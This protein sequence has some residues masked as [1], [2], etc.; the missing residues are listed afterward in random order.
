MTTSGPP[1]RFYAVAAAAGFAFANMAISVPLHTVATGA[2]AAVA[3][4]VLALSTIAVALGALAAGRIRG[5]LRML[6][7][8]VAVCGCGSLALAVATSIPVL[9]LGS[10]VI[11]AGIGMFWVASQLIMSGR[12]GEPDGPNAFLLHYASYTGGTVLG[13]TTTGAFASAAKALGFGTVTGLRASSLLALAVVLTAM[14]LWRVCAAAATESFAPRDAA[15]SPGRQLTVQVPDLLLV[16]GLALLLPLAPVVLAHE[17]RLAPF[18]IGLVMGGVA[19]SKVVGTLVA[20]LVTRGTGARRTIL[21]LL[22]L[23]AVSALV[24]S[25]ALTLSLF[26]T[27][28][29]A[30]ALAGT[31]AWPVVVAAAQARV[32]PAARR[33]LAVRWNAREYGLIALATAT[34]GW[35]L[36]ELGTPA[37][38]FVLAA[39]MFAGA[40]ASAAVVLRRTAA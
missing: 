19:L 10:I 25:A 7:A 33:K 5:G 14:A 26:V 27:M 30:T 18:S 8:A 16:A 35:L 12:A 32:E 31:G 37:P 28:L 13:S 1:R 4:N 17:F 22:T 20:R 39:V 24:L 36:T 40:A 29:F 3:G 15:A 11:G 23:G 9:A 38:I 21:I 34:S 6:A 2:K